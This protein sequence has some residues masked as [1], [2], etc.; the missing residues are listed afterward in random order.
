MPRKPK[1]AT[2]ARHVVVISRNWDNPEINIS[3]TDTLI[4]VAM[5]LPQFLAAVLDELGRPELS[6]EL[7]G[8]VGKVCE[9]MKAE[10]S[11]VM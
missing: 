2:P 3:V 6:D 11:R 8:A 7:T 4:A 1:A 10:T 9:K 5:K